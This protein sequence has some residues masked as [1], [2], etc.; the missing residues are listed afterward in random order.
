MS[1]FAASVR[2]NENG[3]QDKDSLRGGTVCSTVH[4][5]CST[6][7]SNFRCDP[8]VDQSGKRS[9]HLQRQLGGYKKADEAVKHQKCL[10]LQIFKVIWANTFTELDKALGELITGALFFGMRSCEYSTVT[11]ERKTK[12]LR[13][14]N[15]QFML[16]NERIPRVRNNI[17]LFEADSVSITFISQK[18]NE[19]DQTITMHKNGSQLCPV[20]AWACLCLRILKINN[21]SLD[22]PVNTYKIKS[23]I[24]FISSTEV[25]RHIR[26]TVS[27]VGES[28][29]G[30]SSLDVGCHSIRSSFAM[31]LYL[32]NVKTDRIMRQGRWRSDAFLLYIRVQVAAF[33]TGLSTAMIQDSNN[34]FTVPDPTVSHPSIRQE[35]PIFNFDIVSDLADPRCRNP[36]SFASNMNNNGISATNPRVPRQTF[37]NIFS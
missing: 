19:K 11:G 13:L 3:T 5:V 16:N 18:N 7:R 33:S 9:I 35:T 6:F 22:L 10:P 21:A 23:T 37:F 30:F 36:S 31:F 2:R 20:R 4:H 8:T 25:L 24:G 14:R 1:A 34:F 29:L 12:L 28:S 32:Q 15:I 27:I 26:T 17:K